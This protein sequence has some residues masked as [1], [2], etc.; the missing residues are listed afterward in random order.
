MRRVLSLSTSVLALVCCGAVH[1]Q[2]ADSSADNASS[3][4]VETVIVTSERR[5]EDLMKTPISADVISG[6]D[7]QSKGVLKVDDLQFVSPA[8]T[9]NNFGQGIDFNIRGIGKGEHNSQTMTG[10]I[11]YRDGVP[12]FPGYLTEE[13]YYDIAS[14]EILRGPQGTFVGQN[15]TGGAVFAN[16][17]NPTIGGGYDGYG[18][19]QYGNY[20]DVNLQGAVNIP[21]SDTLAVRIAAFGETRDSFY[22]IKDRT[23]TANTFP[24]PFT[25]APDNCPGA[26]YDGCKPGFNPG[27]QKWAAGRVSV[28]WKPTDA[29]TVSFKVDDDYLDSGAYPADPYT[30]RFPV[31]TLVPVHLGGGPATPADTVLLP[32]GQHNDLFHITANS[33]QSALDRLVRSVLKV[34][35]VFGDGITFR[36][37]TGYQQGN[38]A[39][40]ADLDGT[41]MGGLPNTTVFGIVPNNYTFLDR[42]DET[43]YSQEFNLIS[44][45]NQRLTW[46]VGAF[47]QSDRYN[48]KPPFQFLIATPPVPAGEYALQGT[49]PNQGWAVFGQATY[50]VTDS[51]AIQAGGRWSTNMSKNSNVQIVQYGLPLTTNQKTSSSSLDYK[52]SANWQVDEQNFLYAFVSTGY[53]PGGLNL[54]V[55]VGD[56]PV[57]FGPE[58]VT[59]YEGG[60]KATMFDGHIR[61]TLDGYY[62]AYRGFQVTIAYPLFP[63]FGREINVPHQTSIYGME[64]EIEAAFGDF[65]ASAG[66]GLLHSELGGLYAVDSREFTTTAGCDPAAGNP[67]NP[68]CVYLGGHPQTYAPSVSGDISVQYMFHLDGGDSIT[69]RVS[70]AYQGGQWASLFDNPL[71]GDLLAARHLFGAQLE[72]KHDTWVAT[73]YGSNLGDQHY[74]AAMNSGLDFAGPPRQ[75]GIRL[76]KVF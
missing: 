24:G 40:T 66:I 4:T 22:D 74:V 75:F 29:L 50:K 33:P 65:S 60:W 70:F 11:T 68:L 1:A 44:P 15:A 52:V 13:P 64:G 25:A 45:D 12:T 32:N 20:N 69:P 23:T 27:D 7:L 38:T 41:D 35:Y 5:N 14:V 54:P 39:Y 58:R 2:A 16:S 67:A 18:F 3:G 21:L 48:F 43:I 10:V 9:V 37:V 62:N 55:F 31:G 63:T 57:P 17:N 42:V 6:A 36:S 76:L 61:T 34:D 8:V 71:E 19:A 49:N 53:K 28:L 46:V 51:F 56:A 73:L 59:E 30:D 26:K 47:A 72:W